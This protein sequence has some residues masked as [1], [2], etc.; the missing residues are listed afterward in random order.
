MVHGIARR[1]KITRADSGFVIT[2]G[3]PEKRI[4]FTGATWSSWKIICAVP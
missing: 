1:E 3:H 4:W 2:S